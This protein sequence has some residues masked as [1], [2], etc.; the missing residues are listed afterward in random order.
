M[1]ELVFLG[2]GKGQTKRE[3]KEEYTVCVQKGCVA[4]FC[5]DKRGKTN[6]T[7]GS[8]VAS[9]PIKRTCSLWLDSTSGPDGIAHTSAAPKEQGRI[10]KDTELSA[11]TT[12]NTSE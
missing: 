12:P 9:G 1:S 3:R 7:R 8:K 4:S 11:A 6:L 5:L 2:N 10:K